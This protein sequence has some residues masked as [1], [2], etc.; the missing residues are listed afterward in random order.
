[1][2][3]RHASRRTV[4]ALGASGAIAAAVAAGALAPW[5]SRNAEAQV[6][7]A[8]SG[9]DLA[10]EHYD[11]ALAGT[12]PAFTGTEPGLAA[13]EAVLTVPATPIVTPESSIP[14]PTWEP[15]D[16]GM[17]TSLGGSDVAVASEGESHQV[18]G[19]KRKANKI[20]GE[21]KRP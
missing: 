10:T 13:P 17:S 19:P 1:M 15:S 2:T 18:D 4:L 6:D 21:K 5:R 9:E 8:Q 7:P 11:P 14:A 20:L 16:A 3:N 12:D